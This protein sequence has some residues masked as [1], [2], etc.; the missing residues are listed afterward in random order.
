M[1]PLSAGAA[2]HGHAAAT[3]AAAPQTTAAASPVKTEDQAAFTVIGVSVHTSRE[4]EAGGDGEIPKLWRRVIGQG[5]ID[6]IPGN[7]EDSGL[8]AVYSDFSRD[9]YTYTLGTRGASADKVPEGFV[10][11]TV[12]AGKYAVVKSDEG[13]LTEVVPK[14]WRQIFT[15]PASELGGE[16]AFK[17]DYEQFPPNLDYQNAQVE[18]HVGLK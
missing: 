4:Q 18:I 6:Q 1:L 8:V 16:H 13:P 2:L 9:G 11:I 10:A 17:V 15:M 7:H 3:P 14:T 12:P 5:L